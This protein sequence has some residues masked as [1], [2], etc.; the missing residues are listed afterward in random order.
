MPRS[1][2][3][4]TDNGV[5]Y[6]DIT[7]SSTL[8]GSGT[9]YEPVAT[10][11]AN[12]FPA[13]GLLWGGAANVNGPNGRLEATLSYTAT[14][15]GTQGLSSINNNSFTRDAL[16]VLPPGATIMVTTTVYDLDGN[17][18]ATSFLNGTDSADPPTE[19]LSLI[20]I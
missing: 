1:F 11:V 13:S 12:P 14:G 18:L 5:I 16:Q 15:I 4:I 20:H 3:N 17:V 10:V 8:V 19:I 7:V 2:S 6:S 9:N